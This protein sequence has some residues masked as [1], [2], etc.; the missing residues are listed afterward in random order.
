MQ[1]YRIVLEDSVAFKDCG[2]FLKP[3][4]D[5]WF[6]IPPHAARV[7]WDPYKGQINRFRNYAQE[8]VP[9]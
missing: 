9:D 4:S 2:L 3:F 6:S 1:A 5:Q 8:N 7:V